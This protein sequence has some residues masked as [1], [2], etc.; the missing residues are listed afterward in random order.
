MNDHTETP[1]TGAPETDERDPGATEF[2]RRSRGDDTTMD[3]L[4]ELYPPLPLRLADFNE[5]QRRALYWRL[6]R[7]GRVRLSRHFV[8]RQFLYSEIA[9]A[10]GLINLPNDETRTIHAGTKLCER[11]LEP[12]V[13]LFGP[14]IIR[15]GFR[16]AALNAFGHQN[17]LSCASNERNYGR[18]IWDHVDSKGRVGASAC[19]IIPAFNAGATELTS[20]EELA[21]FLKDR[22][23]CD[24]ITFFRRNN[25]FNIGWKEPLIMGKR[26]ERMLPVV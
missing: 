13:A 2:Y 8:M 5:E 17:G 12:I 9:A 24:H 22:T 18:H 20:R 11:I 19:I 10:H 1:N 15:S 6:D 3:T 7:L 25:A 26:G 23:P 21:S 4:T 16:S 14:I